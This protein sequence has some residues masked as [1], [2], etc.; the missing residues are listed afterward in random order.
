MASGITTAFWG[1]VINNYDETDLALVNNGYPDY[2][3]EI[4]VTKEVGKEGTPHLQAWIKLQRQQRLSFVKKLFPR[5]NFKPLTSDEYIRNTKDYAQK[6]DDTTAGATLHRFNDPMNTIESVMKKVIVRMVQDEDEEMD[7][8]TH[9]MRVERAMV[10][11]DYKFAKLFVSSTYKAMWREFGSNM[12][13][14]IFLEQQKIRVCENEHTHTHTHS[15]N[16]FSGVEGINNGVRREDSQE[17]E[18][19]AEDEEEQGGDSDSNT[20]ER[21][22]GETDSSCCS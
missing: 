13:K 21:Y 10:E 2:M 9:R 11:E 17:P 3:R 19:D 5:G 20:G 16:L 14:N 4:I 15:Q 7:M 8:L 12:Y 18:D 6:K 22:D 1:M